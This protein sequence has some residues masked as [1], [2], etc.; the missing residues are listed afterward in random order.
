MVEFHSMWLHPSELP[1]G[2]LVLCSGML[3][4]CSFILSSL[5][6]RECRGSAALP[7]SHYLP[8]GMSRFCSYMLWLLLTFGNVGVM[9][10]RGLTLYTFGNAEVTFVHVMTIM[11]QL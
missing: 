8:S 1:S 4:F 3:G 2:T 10:V 11:Y 6:L 9:L 7:C 5:Y